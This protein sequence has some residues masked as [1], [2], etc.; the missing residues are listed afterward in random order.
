MII[1]IIIL[2]ATTTLEKL[3]NIYEL[4]MDIICHNMLL[5]MHIKI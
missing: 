2:K 4:L 5:Y 3:E 1:I